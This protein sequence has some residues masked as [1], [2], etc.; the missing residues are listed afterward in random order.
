MASI[1][2]GNEIETLER[3]GEFYRKFN[4]GL[5]FEFTF[6]S[7]DYK[8]LYASEQNVAE[9][10]KYFAGVAIMLSCLGLF[11]L[12]IFMAEQRTKEIGIRKVL[13][14]STLGIV[15]LLCK[16]FIRLVLIA[17]LI[18]SPL[19]WWM[20]GTWL[21]DFAYR[22]SI[23]WWMFAITA[24]TAIAIA[25]LTVGAQALKAAISNPV[26]ALRSE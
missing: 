7:E 22:I 1:S 26:K 19:A 10:S 6:L 2:T 16:D 13:G 14:S 15:V 3:I 11:G 23:E 8:A 4:H 21:E 24:L 25:L 5:P 17:I 12:A 18:A 9:L 20:A